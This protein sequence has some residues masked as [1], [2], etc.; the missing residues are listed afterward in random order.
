MMEA[1]FE[2][3]FRCF[4]DKSF[5]VREG[6]PQQHG[7]QQNVTVVHGKNYSTCL[8]NSDLLILKMLI[9]HDNNMEII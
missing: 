2:Y 8:R 5:R 7:Q 1:Y 9:H 6:A 3:T 4:A